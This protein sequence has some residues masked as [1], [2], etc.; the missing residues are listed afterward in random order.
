M[1][2]LHFG[3]RPL[4][5]AIAVAALSVVTVCSTPTRATTLWYNGNYDLNDA[6]TNENNVPINIGGT[7]KLEQALVYDNFVV[8]VGL[9]YVLTSVFSNN[10]IA[11]SA[12]PTTATWQ[13]RTGLSAGK[14][15]TLVASGDT[16]ATETLETSSNASNANNY[17]YNEYQISAAVTGVTLPPGTYWLA[18]APDSLGYYGD[19]SYIETTKGASA[20]GT[21]PGNDGNSFLFNNLTG[22]GAENYVASSLDFSA[23]V[24]GSTVVPEPAAAPM[25][26]FGIAGAFWVSGRRRRRQNDNLP[27]VSVLR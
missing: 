1:P 20:V 4:I 10:Q 6:A 3:R 25:I 13:I 12:T 27:S 5:Q 9:N 19:Q 24:A 14:A 2:S 23:G 18:V 7:Y 16:A 15:G 8:P 17:L 22:T 21:P 26:A 11:Y